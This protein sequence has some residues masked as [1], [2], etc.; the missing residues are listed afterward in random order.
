[1]RLFQGMSLIFDPNCL[2]TTDE[3]LFPASRH[4]SKHITKKLIRRYGGVFRQRPCMFKAGN[5]II[6]HPIYRTQLEAALREAGRP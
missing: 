1:M 4:R 6:A 2:E 5:R 3:R